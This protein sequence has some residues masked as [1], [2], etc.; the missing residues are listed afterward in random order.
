[1]RAIQAEE[2][3]PIF[4]FTLA[5]IALDAGD[6]DW[7]SLLREAFEVRADLR[8]KISPGE[9]DLWC[10]ILH[11]RFGRSRDGALITTTI[12][13]Y[14]THG[15]LAALAVGLVRAIDDLGEDRSGWVRAWSELGAA[16]DEL[17]IA[18]RLLQ[19]A[20]GWLTDRNRRHLLR[21]A[22]EERALLELVLVRRADALK[23]QN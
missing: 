11:R 3:E 13:I 7:A 5:E 2:S 21:L 6:D 22:S 4:R 14:N 17:A 15:E 1:M 16:H 12:D 23:P 20:D 9:P 10:R 19:A 18:I 8:D